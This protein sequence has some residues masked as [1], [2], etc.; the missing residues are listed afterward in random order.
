MYI[1]T[2]YHIPIICSSRKS[3]SVD[4]VQNMTQLISPLSTISLNTQNQLDILNIIIKNN[5]LYY[6]T[7]HFTQYSSDEKKNEI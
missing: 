4:A 6:Y 3:S 5:S 7:H 2:T 1:F